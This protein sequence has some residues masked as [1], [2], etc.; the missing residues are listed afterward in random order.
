MMRLSQPPSLRTR[1]EQKLKIASRSCQQFQNELQL[2]F[3]FVFFCYTG[4]WILFFRYS[5]VTW[6]S[7]LNVRRKKIAGSDDQIEIQ[8]SPALFWN[9]FSI[10]VFFTNRYFK[11]IELSLGK[12]VEF[13]VKK[14]RKE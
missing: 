14:K 5:N 11:E 3:L 7:Q 13:K 1:R 10:F 4:L 6:A 2:S 8:L 9:V 12:L